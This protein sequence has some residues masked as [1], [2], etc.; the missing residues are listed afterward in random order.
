MKAIRIGCGA[1][2]S[3][4][5]IEPAVELAEQGDIGYLVFE[6]LAERT[7]ALAQ[8]AKA[9]NPEAGYDPLLLDRMAAVLPICATG[10]IKI[11]TNMGAANPAAAADAVARLARTL[12]LSGLRIA[13]ITGDDVLADVR[14]G[15]YVVG[16]T[17]APVAAL[18]GQ[19]ISANA[20]LGIE[21]ILDA[22]KGGADV[23]IAGR[24]ADPSLFLAPQVHELG[25]PIDD[26]PR[27]GC[28]TLAGHLLE[29]AGQVTGGYF[30]DP[31]FKDVDGLS[32][33]G[34]PIAEVTEDGAATISKVAGIW[35]ARDDRDLQGTAAL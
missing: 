28:G 26:W 11:L 34:F 10:R 16:E 24:V 13:A 8:Q 9:K 21:P 7:I 6:C 17:G 31:G 2:Y 30:A 29:C 27:L 1:G 4:D 22:L 19:L 5:R 32:R 15:N 33:L 3:G 12:G 18:P 20:Y 23:I 25:W 14:T 35:W